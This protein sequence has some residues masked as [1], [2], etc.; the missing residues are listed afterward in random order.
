MHYIV[1]ASDGGVPTGVG[2]QISADDLKPF[3]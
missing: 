1:T 3:I 2:S